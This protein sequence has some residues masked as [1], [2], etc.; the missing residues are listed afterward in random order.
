[1]FELIGNHADQITII[2][3]IFAGLFA[4]IKWLDTRNQTLKNERYER[5]I[6]HIRI[7]SGSKENEGAFICMTEQIAAAW[8]LLEYSEYFEITLKILDN[9]DLE[10]MSNEPWQQFV[11]PQIKQV[12][13][14]IKSR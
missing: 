14:D 5:Y 13:A 9:P 11:L 1:M 12:I 10:K 8:L 3:A 4:F 6:Q 2:I 7:L